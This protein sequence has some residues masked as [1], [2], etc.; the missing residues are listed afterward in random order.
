[1]LADLQVLSELDAS[2]MKG[3]FFVNSNS[4]TSRPIGTSG[5][6]KFDPN[7]HEGG[8]GAGNVDSHWCSSRATCSYKQFNICMAGC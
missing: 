3:T 7:W 5:R 2:I 6:L 1:M 8:T 4:F